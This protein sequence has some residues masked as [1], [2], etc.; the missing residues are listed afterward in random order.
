MQQQKLKKPLR[1]AH[2]NSNKTAVLKAS[3]NFMDRD[4]YQKN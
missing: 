2:R 3:K 4:K 1:V